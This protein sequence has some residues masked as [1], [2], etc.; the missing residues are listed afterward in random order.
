MTWDIKIMYTL[1][2]SH[3]M[4]ALRVARQQRRGQERHMQ[5]LRVARQHID[6]KKDI[7]KQA[8]YS[9]IG[10]LLAE[11]DKKDNR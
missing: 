5:A 10:L 1:N 11:S 6:S 8:R 2:I 3:S 4:Q 9:M 7:H